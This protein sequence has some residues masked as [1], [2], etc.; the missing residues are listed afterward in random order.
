MDQMAQFVRDEGA[1]A[2]PVFVGGAA[3]ESSLKTFS[4]YDVA[5]AVWRVSRRAL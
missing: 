5:A 1:Q 4:P 2:A 3:L